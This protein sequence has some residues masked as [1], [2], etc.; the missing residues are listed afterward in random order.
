[1]F[2]P[3]AKAVKILQDCIVPQTQNK[4]SRVY[5]MG[6]KRAVFELDFYNVSYIN[7]VPIDSNKDIIKINEDE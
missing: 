3:P 6:G 2:Y 4:S 5:V 1:M 7:F